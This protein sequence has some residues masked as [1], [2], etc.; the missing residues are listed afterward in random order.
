LK[1]HDFPGTVRTLL[2]TLIGLVSF[3]YVIILDILNAMK[4][5]IR[6]V[7]DFVKFTFL[8]PLCPIFVAWL[9]SHLNLEIKINLNTLDNL[10]CEALHKLPGFCLVNTSTFQAKTICQEVYSR[11]EVGNYQKDI[12]LWSTPF[13]TRFQNVLSPKFVNQ[14]FLFCS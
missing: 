11:N 8:V 10:R 14:G 1:F 2:I 6:R 9:F 13:E 4:F 12:L 5:W 3:I 7:L